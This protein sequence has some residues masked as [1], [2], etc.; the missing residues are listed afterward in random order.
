MKILFL[1]DNLGSGGAEKVLIDILK[2]INLNKYEVSLLLIRNKGVYLK[3]I[4]IN[5]KKY[6]IYNDN[7]YQYNK[8]IYKLYYFITKVHFKI[9]RII[10]LKKIFR[11]N[12]IDKY[13]VYIPFL[14]GACIQLIADSKI[15]GKKIA[16]IHTDLTK[17]AIMKQKKELEVLNDMNKII[18]VSKSSKEALVAKYYQ[19]EDKV[20][21][22]T[23]PIDIKNIIKKS[24]EPLEIDNYLEGDCPVFISVG[25]IERVKGFDI[26]LEA[27]RML[28]KEGINHKIIILGEG[29]QER[30]LKNLIEKYD[31]VDS[32]KLY[33]YKKNPY[34]YI[35]KADY[36]VM[37]S[38]YEGYPLSLC[39]SIALEKPIIASDFPAA[40]EILKDGKLG[41][42]CKREDV[43]DL[44]NKMKE[45]ICDNKLNDFLIEN[46]RS[47]KEDFDFNKKIEE[48][49]SVIKN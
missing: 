32:F 2:N 18:C 4:P 34:T 37:P 14:E 16:W 36:F 12:I 17:H 31:V 39:E 20:M 44:K 48:I 25:R 10:G 6:Y 35:K 42:I 40:F 5:V 7:K 29:S 46:C 8:I 30:E 49:E 1:I 15:E 41:V 24:N 38:R 27:H 19:L 47:Y 33:G 43:I 13:D 23:N 28:L 3:D 11:K 26:L 21:I 22:I 9:N 45:L